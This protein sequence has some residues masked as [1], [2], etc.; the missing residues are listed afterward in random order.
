MTGGR[1]THASPEWDAESWWRPRTRCPRALPPT[2]P[3][4][5]PAAPQEIVYERS[6][7]YMMRHGHL[8]PPLGVRILTDADLSTAKTKQG[9]FVQKQV[10]AGSGGGVRRLPALPAQNSVGPTQ[11]TPCSRGGAVPC[12]CG[13]PPHAWLPADAPRRRPVPPPQLETLVNSPARNALAARAYLAKAS[14]RRAVVFCVGV[15]VRS[16][17]LGRRTLQVEGKGEEAH[18]DRHCVL[19]AVLRPPSR[20]SHATAHAPCFIQAFLALPH[21]PSPHSLW[22]HALDMA[23]AFQE[24]GVPCEAVHGQLPPAEREALLQRFKAG[25][26]QV[27]GGARTSAPYRQCVSAHAANGVRMWTPAVRAELSFGALCVRRA[28]VGGVRMPRDCAD[29]CCGKLVNSVCLLCCRC[30]PTV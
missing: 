7:R 16:S 1:A 8:V 27:G 15:Q 12:L 17:G 20:S 21:R 26:I 10:R 18:V 24:A 9:D 11:C 19:L 30:S 4:T 6:L 3:P 13:A 14:C 22:Q 5:R 29:R 25:E 23:T 2:C 28:S